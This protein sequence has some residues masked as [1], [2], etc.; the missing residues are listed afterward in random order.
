MSKGADPLVQ[1][2]ALLVN[3]L[4]KVGLGP[5]EKSLASGATRALAMMKRPTPVS[6]RLY[7]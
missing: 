5:S 3:L 6:I 1:T 4:I 7:P 2:L